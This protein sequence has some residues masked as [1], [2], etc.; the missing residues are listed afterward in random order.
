MSFK[1]IQ[2]HSLSSLTVTK[3]SCLLQLRLL[4]VSL[5]LSLSLP[6]LLDEPVVIDAKEDKELAP[7]DMSAGLSLHSLHAALLLHVGSHV[8]GFFLWPIVTK[9]NEKGLKQRH[10]KQCTTTSSHNK[11]AVT[12]NL[13]YRQGHTT[14]HRRHLTWSRYFSVL[15]FPAMA[16][17]VCQGG[18]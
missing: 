2:C 4:D 15:H 18:R 17:Y 6:L 1:A 11:L 13:P 16:L 10:K 12:V 8:Q 3:L 9:K 7:S 5:S 14:F